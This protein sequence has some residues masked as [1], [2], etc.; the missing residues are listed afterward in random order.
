MDRF[1]AIQ[2]RRSVRKYSG[3]K[4]SSTVLSEVKEE[5]KDIVPLYKNIDSKIVLA[6]DGKAIQETFSGLKSKIARVDAPHYLI[7]V[8]E[9]KDGYLE[10]I[11]YMMEEAVL[12]LTEKKI[13]TCWLGSGIEHDLLKDL[14]DYEG[15]TVILVA[16][17]DSVPEKNN[18]RK[19]PGSASR[20]D[21]E[22][23][24]IN[25]DIPKDVKKII[26]TA[27]MAPSALNSQPWRFFYEDG[28]IHVYIEKKGMFKNLVRKIGDLDKLNHIDVG[29]ALKHLEIGAENYSKKIRF[30]DRERKKK[31]Y[32]YITSASLE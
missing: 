23:I 22:E 8:S 7:G 11:G 20:K 4:L 12:Y 9:E 30:T 24:V 5:I 6:E 25:D 15:N 17:G 32:E 2:R 28:M 27:R 16:F 18:L 13:G 26:E 3:E 1:K 19:D 10:N 29:I 31:G 14:F 21:L